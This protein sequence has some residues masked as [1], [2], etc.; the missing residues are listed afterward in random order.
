MPLTEALRSDLNDCVDFCRDTLFEAVKGRLQ[1]TYGISPDGRIEDEGKLSLSG[2]DERRFRRRLVTHVE[3][4][5]AQMTGTDK[6]RAQKA[7]VKLTRAA[8]FTHLNR[9]CAYKMLA[10][11]KVIYDPIG[12]GLQSR[13]VKF[14]CAD[15]LG[16]PAVPT[17]LEEE[18][19]YREFLEWQAARLSTQVEALFSADDPAVWLYP[20]QRTLEAVLAKLNQP[21]L[22]GVWLEDDT[23]GW[24][25]QFFNSKA[26]V[27]A[28][29][30]TKNGGSA[31]PRNSY[32]MAV[33]NQ[34][35]TPRYIVSFIV[36]N[37]LGRLWIEM[38]R[39]KSKLV[40]RCTYF[41]GELEEGRIRTPKD[42]RT[43]RILDPA[44]GSGHFLIYIFD[45]LLT[46]YEEA[47]DDEML[48]AELRREYPDRALFLREVPKLIVEN[49]LWGVDIDRRAAQ[50]AGLVLMLRAQ[51]IW[52][53][54]GVPAAERPKIERTHIVCAEPMPGEADLFE[55]FAATLNPTVAAL[56]RQ[57][58]EKMANADTLGTLL[59]VE[60]DLRES[61][62]EARRQFTSQGTQAVQ[63]SLDMDMARAV[64]VQ[65]T[66]DLSGVAEETFFDN[67]EEQ[68]L[69]ALAR[70]AKKAQKQDDAADTFG[71]SRQLFAGD[72][73]RGFAF[74]ELCRQKF[75]VVV[76][77]PPFGD[78]ATPSK[79]YL[80]A[81]YGDTKGDVYKAFIECFQDR[82]VPGGYLGAITSRT[83]FF[84]GQ[85]ANWRERVL[86]RLYRPLVLLDLGHG[87]LDAMVETA[88]YVLRSLTE[89]ERATLT[90]S[91]ARS[92]A[93]VKRDK[94]GYFSRAAYEKRNE[95]DPLKRHQAEQELS[96]LESEGYV[97]RIV[98]INPTTGKLR[99]IKFALAPKT[100]ALAPLTEAEGSAKANTTLSCLRLLGGKGNVEKEAALGEVMGDTTDKR[101]FV[102]DV[103]D[104]DKV[105]GSPFTYWVDNRIRQLF[106]DFPAFDSDD[107]H[108]CITNPAG[109]NMRYIRNSWE[110]QSSSVGRGIRWVPFCKGGSYSLYYSD[111]HLL[112]DWDED[113]KTFLGFEG[114]KHRPLKKPAS[115][116]YF[117]KSGVSWPAR[118]Q[119]GLNTRILPGGCIFGPKGPS[120]FSD[121]N[122]NS[123]LGLMNSFIFRFLTDLLI[124]FGSYEVGIIQKIP[125]PD[126]SG[127]VGGRLGELALACVEIKR[128]LDT[129]S[130]I[131]HV[132]QLPA[133]LQAKG[134][135]LAERVAD[136]AARVAQANAD[137]ATNQAEIDQI[138]ARLYGIEEDA[139]K[140]GEDEAIAGSGD[141]DEPQDL[142]EGDEDDEEGADDEEDED[143]GVVADPRQFA[144][145]LISYCVGCAFGRFDIRVATSQK[146]L[147]PLP[148]PFAPLPVCSPGMLTGEDGLPC[149]MPDGYPLTVDPDGILADDADEEGK[150]YRADDIVVRVHDVLKLLFGSRYDAIEKE[151]CAALGVA[152]LRDYFRKSSVGGFFDD[153]L[154]RYSKSRRKAPIY[155]PLQSKKKALTLWVYAHSYDSDTLYKARQHY[156]DIALKRA[157]DALAAAQKTR[158]EHPVGSRDRRQAE[159]AADK[160]E[161]LTIEL[162]NFC[163]KLA[164]A[165]NLGLNP[166]LNDGIVLT[167]APLHE[168]TP[169]KE[170]ATY[171]KALQSGKYPWS[172]IQQ[173]L[174]AKDQLS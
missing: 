42:P 121:K 141:G 8:T 119:K 30:D 170:A 72:A 7:V 157:K 62:A 17:G 76:M 15:V 139:L 174:Q 64:T 48:G 83:G 2:K 84:L 52:Q 6:E 130:E 61:I 58:F 104:F 149:A 51:R 164:E 160:Y 93:T 66:I 16:I 45:L 80:E 167:V 117:F 125:V 143:T 172:S 82:L 142:A 110:P 12:Q 29:K 127:E 150:P 81:T 67:V 10:A 101:R 5:A 89:A 102:V 158:D 132:F 65:R 47:Y 21:G 145:D 171:W 91:L 36:D 32:E 56:T 112:V 162:G 106:I 41:M 156:A 85:S 136:W 168:L 11:R 111:I 9:L 86:L 37:S 124:S 14:Y 140:I 87:V 103:V 3:H 116:D 120:A 35:F 123:V 70:Y 79:P 44:C 114:T 25:F 108:A 78:A 1:A 100:L 113:E 95:A 34:F 138:A 68:V 23:I 75:D 153:H 133:I 63:I 90:E 163:D 13:G 26:E 151:V 135:S 46:I 107:R 19:F 54:Q 57:V 137:V 27:K 71:L 96:W 33:R 50:I 169:W 161:A 129:T 109:D 69:E 99:P 118:T 146:T 59:K 88:A 24:V 152:T 159:R 74:V 154:K 122:I 53:E 22:A 60:D 173:Q 128:S 97:R 115:V 38:R 4:L 31:S 20:P 131:S 144:V 165:A 43:L 134:D 39:G 77:N 148:D 55:E 105:P 155:W 147:P 94:K 92:L 166:D 28:L 98:E 126:L 49:N 73:A 18:G 40:E